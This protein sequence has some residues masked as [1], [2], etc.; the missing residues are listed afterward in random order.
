MTAQ[1]LTLVGVHAHA[2]LATAAVEASYLGYFDVGGFPATTTAVYLT[3][4][5]QTP[6][7]EVE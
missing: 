2:Y 7:V 6:T 3:A 5:A 4:S 1:G